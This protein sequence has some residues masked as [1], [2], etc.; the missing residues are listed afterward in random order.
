V[1]GPAIYYGIKW[2]AKRREAKQAALQ[3]KAP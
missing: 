2:R 1:L 3:S